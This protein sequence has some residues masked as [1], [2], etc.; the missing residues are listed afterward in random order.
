M[1]KKPQRFVPPVNS[2][3]RAAPSL[4]DGAKLSP[5]ASPPFRTQSVQDLRREMGI[6]ESLPS[7]SMGQSRLLDTLEDAPIS[8]A[9]TDKD[10][11]SNGTG[12]GDISAIQCKIRGIHPGKAQN[13]INVL[14]EVTQ[15]ASITQLTAAAYRVFQNSVRFKR[16][17]VQCPGCKITFWQRAKGG[18]GQT[19]GAPDIHVV[20]ERWFLKEPLPSQVKLGY[21]TALP[22]ALWLPIEQKGT[23]TVLSPEQKELQKKQLIC[24]ARSAQASLSFAAHVDSF[25]A[26]IQSLMKENEEMKTR[27]KHLEKRLQLS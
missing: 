18:T 23:Q 25:F 12:S 7:T 13:K 16:F 21:K 26:G 1:Q 19:K 5:N 3:R 20:S 24:L 4:F 17:Q 10:A 22:S 27:I 2:P 15:H 11:Q 6:D 8:E 14:E 9:E